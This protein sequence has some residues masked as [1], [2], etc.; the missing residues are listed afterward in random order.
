MR[1]SEGKPTLKAL[2][3]RPQVTRWKGYRCRAGPGSLAEAAELSRCAEQFLG[4]A[5]ALLQPGLFPSLKLPAARRP[6]HICPSLCALHCV[7]Y[8][9]LGEFEPTGKVC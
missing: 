5:L 4:G 9:A 2:L 1:P 8:T 6:Y 7:P 3:L